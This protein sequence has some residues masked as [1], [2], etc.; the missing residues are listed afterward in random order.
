MEKTPNTV[1]AGMSEPSGESP[2]T[3]SGETK[4]PPN[5]SHKAIRQ[6]LTNFLNPAFPL[7]KK[8]SD[9]P[10]ADP[11]GALQLR[12][13]QMELANKMRL[14]Q[15]PVSSANKPAPPVHRPPASG[16]GSAQGVFH[17]QRGDFGK[18]KPPAASK[19]SPYQQIFANSSKPKESAPEEEILQ[20]PEGS[21]VKQEDPNKR[22]RTKRFRNPSL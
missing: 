3:E 9:A 18:P 15:N 4:S 20:V 19:P 11:Q 13:A 8:P 21:E 14:T 17:L 22:E 2:N 6:N 1:L 7:P 12:M 16:F 5:D 10:E